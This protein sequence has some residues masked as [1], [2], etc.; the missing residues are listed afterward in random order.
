M[1]NQDIIKLLGELAVNDENAEERLTFT[2]TKGQEL[3]ISFF[4]LYIIYMA[5]EHESCDKG[6]CNVIANIPDTINTFLHQFEKDLR[7]HV[8]LN[9]KVNGFILDKPHN[10][11]VYEEILKETKGQ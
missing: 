2:I 11:Q 10:Q 4:S 9:L 7:E 6:E 1:N 3:T 5:K 8:E